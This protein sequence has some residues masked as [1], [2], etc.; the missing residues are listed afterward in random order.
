M[1]WKTV[2]FW[3]SAR[4]SISTKFYLT[5]VNLMAFEILTELLIVLM[6]SL[7]VASMELLIYWLLGVN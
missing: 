5:S 1:F 3:I 6:K 7:K 4:K 2:D